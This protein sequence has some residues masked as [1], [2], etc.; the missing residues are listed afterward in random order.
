MNSMY[1]GVA[2]LSNKT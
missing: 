1:I 2:S